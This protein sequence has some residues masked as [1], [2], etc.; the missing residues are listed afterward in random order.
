[1]DQLDTGKY[2]LSLTDKGYLL[3]RIYTDDEIT[4]DDVPPVLDFFRRFERKMPVLLVREGGYA[5]SFEAQSA[6][7]RHAAQLISRLAFVDRSPLQQALTLLAKQTYL[8]RLEVRSCRN[9]EEAE[10]WLCS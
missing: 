6:L 4:I 2:A 3:V 7:M 5:L 8:K 1:M 10:A 9:V